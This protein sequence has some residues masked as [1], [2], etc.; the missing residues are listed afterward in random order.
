MRQD[1]D[2]YTKEDFEVWKILFDRQIANL[3]TKSCSEYLQNLTKLASVLNAERIPNFDELNSTLRSENGWSIKV[4]PGLIPVDQFFELLAE[5]RFCSSTW[6]RKRS[7]LDYLQEPDMFHDIFGH[8][9]LLMHPEYANFTQKV[10][11]LGARYK[12]NKAILNGLENLYWFT[13]EFGL[14]KKKEKR[15]IYGAG[16]ISSFGETNHIYSDKVEIRPFDLIEIINMSFVNSEIQ[17]LYFEI[18]SF[19]QLFQT[20]DTLETRWVKMFE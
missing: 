10:G 16:I 20:V 5:K 4:V 11:Q 13:I 12:D 17:N 14:I 6:L 7:Q 19:E 1:Y 8:I 15:E 2:K 3:Q 18:D 9:A